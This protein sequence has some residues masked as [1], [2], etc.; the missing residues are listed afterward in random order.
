[1][2]EASRIQKLLSDQNAEIDRL[3]EEIRQLR[4]DLSEVDIGFYRFLPKQQAGLLT[5]LCRRE[6]AT[7]DYLDHFTEENGHHNRYTGEMHQTLR[8]KVTMW[9]MRNTLRKYGIEIKVLRSVGYSIDDEN[10][11]KLTELIRGIKK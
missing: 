4:K 10:K 6:V 7:F 9:K 8:T 11:Q 2:I 3:K 5:A 1:M